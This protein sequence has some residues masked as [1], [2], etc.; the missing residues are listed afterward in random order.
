MLLVGWF[1]GGDGFGGDSGRLQM[2]EVGGGR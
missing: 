1:L 2:M